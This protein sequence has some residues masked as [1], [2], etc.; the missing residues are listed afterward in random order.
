MRSLARLFV[1]LLVAF[2]GAAI[3]AGPGKGAVA[4][5]H[6]LATQAGLEILAKGGNAFDAAVATSAALGVVEPFS[7]GLGGGGFWLLHLEETDR[8]V[9]VDGRETAPGAATRDM[10][11]DANGDP[12]PRASLDG[13]LAAG[14]PGLPAT[15]V[16]VAGRYGRLPLSETL[17]PAIRLA[18][19]GFALYERMH[20]GLTY[21]AA[22]LG[23]YPASAEAFLVDGRVPDIGAVIRLPGLAVVM[24]R[25][26]TGGF[27]GFYRGE[28]ARGIVDAVRANGGIF[29]LEDLAAYEVVE[30][31]PLYGRYRDVDLVLPPPPSAG[32]VALI[33]ALNILAAYDLDRLDRPARIH[34]VVEALRRAFRDRAL[35]GDPAFVEIPVG[36]LTDPDYAA[37]LAATIRL[38]RATPSDVFA[39]LLSRDEGTHTTHFSVIDDD[40]NRVAATQTINGWFGSGFVVPGLDLLLN[41]EMDDFSVKA[42]V[43][44][45]FKLV[46]ADANAVGPGR[47]MLSSMTPAFLESSRGVAIL[48]TP[49]GSRIISMVLLASLAWI[50]GA[51]AAEM[52]ALPRYH[53][54]Y[55]PDEI[56]H[57][58]DAFTPAEAAF[59]EG[60]GHALRES[61]RR[62][63]NLNVVTWDAR[64]G[65]VEAAPDPRGEGAGRVY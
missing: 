63:G 36:R 50:D 16:H 49:G 41:N 27:D 31:E 20:V 32:G 57:E 23:S 33:E 39:P 14:I 26:A 45:L 65:E 21:K 51:T 46:G 12:V 43:P 61:G 19:E 29:S 22:L 59:L 13:P 38:D 7:S 44:N 25:L 15:L 9:F 8:D 1:V 58:P 34:L 54:Q 47:R 56:V 42:G 4:S 52:A 35:L 28:T 62:Y 2:P 55:L 40:G 37:G 60:L 30:R 5:A 18:R 17:A 53:H 48:G 6:P 3:G 11:L 10:Y 24:E 64:T